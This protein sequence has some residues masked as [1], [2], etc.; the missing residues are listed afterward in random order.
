VSESVPIPTLRKS[1]HLKENNVLRG[2]V[3]KA[4]EILL[5]LS[6]SNASIGR[7]ILPSERSLDFM[8]RQQKAILAVKTKADM[9]CEVLSEKLAS[10]P[11]E[12]KK[13]HSSDKYVAITTTSASK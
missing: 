2:K 4:A 5:W 10:N 13:T 9:S 3:T 12:K 7:V 8:W 6:G 1:L 11:A